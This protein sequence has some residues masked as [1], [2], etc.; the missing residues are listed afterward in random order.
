[1]KDLSFWSHAT[2]N[3]PWMVWM[4]LMVLLWHLIPIEQIIKPKQHWAF[5][6]LTLYPLNKP[7]RCE[8][9]LSHFSRV[10]LCDPM[11]CSPPGSLVHGIFQAW[12][13]EWVAVSFSRGSSWPRDQTWVS[14]AIGRHFTVWATREALS[15]WDEDKSQTI[16]VKK[17]L[18]WPWLPS[19]LYLGGG[20]FNL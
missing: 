8:S 5:F 18:E 17:I 13:L 19:V 20:S 7:M 2:W 9:M 3:I 1:M 16:Q 6:I 15:W 12:I 11:D 14:C 10:R 4:L